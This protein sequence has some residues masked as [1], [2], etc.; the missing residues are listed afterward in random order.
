MRAGKVDLSL[1]VPVYNSEKTLDE[2]V[3][4]I[5]AEFKNDLSFEIIL[6]NDGSKDRSAD[7]AKRL[8]LQDRSV[9]FVSF[10]KNFGQPSALFAGFREAEGDVCV[11]LD[12]DLQNPPEEIRKLLAQLEQGFDFVFGVSE[13]R[14]QGLFRAL[15]SWL[16]FKMAHFLFDMPRHIYPSSFLAMN[17]RVVEEVIKYEGPYPYLSGLIFRVS[18]N[19]ASIPVKQD[20]RKVGRSQY[21]FGKL[22]RLWLNGFTNF[23]IVPLR[24]SSLIGACVA[25]AGFSFLG[26]IV[27]QKLFFGDFMPGWTSILGSV[28]LFSGIQLLAVGILG[29]YAGRIFMLLN[30]SPQYCVRE[31]INCSTEY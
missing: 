21:S 11:I 12:D 6:V 28:L 9:K 23:S 15:A 5:K 30:K 10:L 8:A 31:K 27:V 24:I 20:P 22:I 7:V 25:F 19:G 14:Q 13:L 26:F 16:T 1:V 18:L 17:R 4:R 29:E 2:L 3:S